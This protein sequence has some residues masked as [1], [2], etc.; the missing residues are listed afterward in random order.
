MGSWMHGVVP[1]YMCGS[2]RTSGVTFSLCDTEK[3]QTSDQLLCKLPGTPVCSSYFTTVMTRSQ[4]QA[5]VP[6]FT[7]R[8]RTDIQVL[9]LAW[10]VL[11]SISHNKNHCIY[12]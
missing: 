11:Y 1:W 8:L 3:K 12:S 7:G 5:T 10:H 2:Q 6:G 4:K 9:T